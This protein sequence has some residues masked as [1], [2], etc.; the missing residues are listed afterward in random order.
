MFVLDLGPAHVGVFED[1]FVH[2]AFDIRHLRRAEWGAAEVERQFFGSDVRSFLDRVFADDFVERPVQEVGNR[3]VAFDGQAPWLIDGERYGVARSWA[4]ETL[5]GR[6][7]PAHKM[8][9][10]IACLLSIH[11]APELPGRPKLARVSHLSA[12]LGVKRG[13]VQD[14]GGAVLDFYRLDDFGRRLNSSTSTLSPRSRA[15]SSVK[16]NGKP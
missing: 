14:Q 12:H 6:V 15:I 13:D 1:A 2:E 7:I 5:R 4:L 10:G 3:M 11:D 16:S 8:K 9:P